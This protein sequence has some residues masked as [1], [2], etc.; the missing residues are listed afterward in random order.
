MKAENIA[1][2][3][4]YLPRICGIATF[5]TD[6]CE[7]VAKITANSRNIMAIA[8]NNISEGY[9]YPPRVKFEIGQG[10][11]RDY[12]MAANYINHSGAQCVCLQHEYG[13]F[14]GDDGIFI[15]QLISSLSIPVVVTLHTVMKAPSPNQKKIIEQMGR[16][17]SALV[18]MSAKAVEFLKT[19]YKIPEEK[20]H[21]I[22]HGIP[23]IPFSEEETRKVNFHLE[24]RP[25]LMSFGLLSPN[26]GI[27]V[28]LKAIS[29]LVKKYP[30]LSY[31]ILGAT[32]PELKKQDGEG[33]RIQ[34]ERQVESLGIGKNVLFH[35]RFVDLQTLIAYLAATDIYLTP[36]WSEAQI[37]SGALAYAM[38]SGSAIV[39][40]PYWYAEEMLAK[41]R[42]FLFPFGDDKKLFEILDTLL[43]DK[44]LLKKSKMESY[45]YSRRM[46]W[47][48]VARE[49]ISL[50]D[51]V[52][53]EYE[54]DVIPKIGSNTVVIPN[55]NLN[56][57]RRL[58]D[59]T[60]MIEHAKF[61]IPKRDEGYCLDDN[62]RAL[63]VSARTYH[64]TRESLASELT[65][66]YMGYVHHCQREDG[67]FH[68]RINY[69]RKTTDEVGSDDCIGRTIWAL[70][71]LVRRPPMSGHRSIADECFQKVIPHIS[72]FS[73]RGKTY[74]LPGL[75]A[76]LKY[77]QGDENV[78][79]ILLETAWWIIGQY[80]ANKDERWHW[81]EDELTY[82]NAM[83]PFALLR[84]YR[85]TGETKFLEV[86][87]ESLAFL[88]NVC[89]SNGYL[90]PVGNKG[91]Y[92]KGGE[93]AQYDQ[94]PLDATA[95]VLAYREAF[96]CTGN[97][98]YIQQMRLSFGWFL[99]DNDL[100]ISLYDH[101]SG[102]C[103]DGLKKDDI[104]LNQGAESTLSFLMALLA[105]MEMSPIKDYER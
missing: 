48:N 23:E 19:I 96:R 40:T 49:Y 59:D 90:R 9:D 26:K 41:N 63:I 27:E 28:S 22:H 72:K 31:I 7:S 25:V 10:N 51:Q 14:G 3:G 53:F 2:V 98:N 50:F 43:S 85:I 1:F 37:T 55:L 56:H 35:N 61:V 69:Q 79:Q 45:E 44:E 58:T 105:T 78:R 29:Q 4:N 77:H 103:S 39:S 62:A 81:F 34:L 89:F 68:N 101:Q 6:L 21:L 38:G 66:T 17:C 54:Q 57:L 88:E 87:I 97:E 102:G 93:V 67:L 70:G 30:E 94:Q 36:Y 83:I 104:N 71:H 92:T 99:G 100:G 18:V 20:I 65:S 12:A 60:G 13:I 16:T 24:G 47:D 82:D 33:Y 95:F 32:H 52:V 84:S 74:A 8:I 73:L 5:N 76:Y 86:G 64:L 46:I 15:L 11:Y 42:G 80:H 91:W 75:Y